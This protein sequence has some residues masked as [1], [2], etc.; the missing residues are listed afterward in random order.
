MKS[1][2]IATALVAPLFLVGSSACS[3]EEE[4]ANNASTSTTA[5]P[6]QQANDEK[7]DQGVDKINSG[8]SAGA[9]DLFNQITKSDPENVTAF[10]NL[11][12]IATSSGD[13]KEAI[14]SYDK[15]LAIDPGHTP[16]MY[17]KALLLKDTDPQAAAA[18]LE[19]IIE[20][21][22]EASTAYL[23]LGIIQQKAGDPAADAN[24]NKA[25]EIDPG[26]AEFA[27]QFQAPQAEIVEQAPLPD[28]D[29]EL[30]AEEN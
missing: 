9:K 30:P 11:G 13:S 15:A 16:S 25:V 7:T 14:R 3:N 29:A 4:P 2:R 5:N 24:I 20:L 21:K 26:L 22:P 1:H 19:R 27:Q 18:I 10:Y 17:N 28:Q 6:Q 23:N 8:D 12:I